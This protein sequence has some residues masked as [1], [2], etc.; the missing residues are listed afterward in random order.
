LCWP[1]ALARSDFTAVAD[2]GPTALVAEKRIAA[3]V[4]AASKC[5]AVGVAAMCV[6]LESKSWT[7][8]WR[9]SNLA[10]GETSGFASPPHDGFALKSALGWVN[11]H[12]RAPA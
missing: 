7:N 10:L 4:A 2:D 5:R 9:L 3:A 8:S 11:R 12:K 1:A 6:L